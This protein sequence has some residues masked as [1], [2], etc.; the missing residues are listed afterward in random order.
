MQ[1]S[2]LGARPIFVQFDR[3]AIFGEPTITVEM[4]SAPT[5]IWVP[6]VVIGD[7]DLMS[8]SLFFT[9]ATLQQLAPHTGQFSQLSV[10]HD[11]TGAQFLATVARSALICQSFRVASM[12]QRVQRVTVVGVLVGR[13]KFL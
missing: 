6:L 13:E 2:H 3:N 9:S 8:Q 7:V 4:L 12:H 10:D 1:F 5:K 11:H